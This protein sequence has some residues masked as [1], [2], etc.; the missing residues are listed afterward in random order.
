MDGQCGC[1]CTAWVGRTGRKLH[2]VV[3]TIQVDDQFIRQR[4][5]AFTS[6]QA[7]T[8][9]RVLTS[10]GE[11]V[12]GRTDATICRPTRWS[13]CRFRPRRIKADEPASTP[14]RLSAILEADARAL[15]FPA[16]GLSAPQTRS[17]LPVPAR[18]NCNGRRLLAGRWV[19]GPGTCSR[20]LLRRPAR[21]DRALVRNSRLVPAAFLPWRYG[22]HGSWPTR[23]LRVHQELMAAAG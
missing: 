3:R 8:P 18:L 10:D 20:L 23:P 19:D 17:G 13:A 11:V 14:V 7:L 12:A 1:C 15:P 16:A 9:P 4:K 2:G 22:S 6:Y 5:D 21:A